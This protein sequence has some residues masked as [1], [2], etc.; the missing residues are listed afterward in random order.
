MHDTPL[1]FINQMA[2]VLF[3]VMPCFRS[4]LWK[5]RAFVGVC[6]VTGGC[7]LQEDV[8]MLLV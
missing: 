7:M 1:C 2:V 8:H 6:S 5:S 3:F 4:K